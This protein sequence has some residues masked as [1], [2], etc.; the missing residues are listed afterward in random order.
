MWRPLGNCPV[1]PPPL[2]SAMR[3]HTRR[4]DC[5]CGWM[6]SVDR[7]RKVAAAATGRQHVSEPRSYTIIRLFLSP[8][9]MHTC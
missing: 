6:Q 4:T 9:Y 1:C 7:G 5:F 3:S 8:A 2:K